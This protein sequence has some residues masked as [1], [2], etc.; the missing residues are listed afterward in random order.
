MVLEDFGDQIIRIYQNH[1]GNDK[2][3][4]LIKQAGSKPNFVNNLGKKIKKV[5]IINE[6]DSIKVTP[7]G[8]IDKQI[9]REIND[10]LRLH[11]FS[12]LSNGKDSC[13]LKMFA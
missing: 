1:L 10:I 5:T 6:R 13:W 3:L 8:W 9:W 11:K 7:K 2:Y 4:D 12:W